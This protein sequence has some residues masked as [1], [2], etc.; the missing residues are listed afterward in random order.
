M[1]GY[2]LQV[3][4]FDKLKN[5]VQLG[6]LIK[7]IYDNPRQIKK[8]ESNDEFPFI[9]IGNDTVRPW[10]TDTELGTDADVTIHVW[11]RANHRLECK[12]IQDAIYNALHRQEISITGRNFV[13][14][15]MVNQDAQRDEDGLTIHGIQ[16]FK[17]IFEV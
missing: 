7:G 10:D 8:P 12:Q 9:T 13:G 1:S 17:L 2:L 14:C 16:T 4:I 5:S 3:A 15:D 11:S 6:A